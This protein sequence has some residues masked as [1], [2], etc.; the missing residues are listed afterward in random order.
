[1]TDTDITANVPLELVAE[2]PLDAIAA[3]KQQLADAITDLVD[4]ADHRLGDIDAQIA[5]L[6]AARKQLV[7]E[8][9]SHR[10]DLARVT[11]DRPDKKP[12]AVPTGDHQCKHCERSFPTKQGLTMHNTRSHKLATLARPAAAPTASTRTVYRC[13][14][15]AGSV[16]CGHEVKNLSD[17]SHHVLV[18]HRRQPTAAEKILVTPD[19]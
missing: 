2:G 13:G 15:I 1:M 7:D 3:L 19:R 16:A 14:E 18:E 10:A 17:L 11:G 9:R 5:D 12:T 4:D 6:Q 8:V